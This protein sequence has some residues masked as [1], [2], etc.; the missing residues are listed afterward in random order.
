MEAIEKEVLD[1]PDPESE[2]KVDQVAEVKKDSE[3]PSP[4][5]DEKPE[6]EKED[7]PEVKKNESI[8]KPEPEPP[9]LEI[10]EESYEASTKTDDTPE[11]TYPV[12]A[13]RFAY[14]L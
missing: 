7:V 3:E 11:D 13:A 10:K 6:L 5:K 9:K 14:R 1:T 8:K 4:E 12:R 2:P